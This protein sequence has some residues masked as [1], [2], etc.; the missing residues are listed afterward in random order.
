MASIAV[1]NAF[2]MGRFILYYD[3]CFLLH[4]FL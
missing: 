3:V 2:V 1:L 4:A